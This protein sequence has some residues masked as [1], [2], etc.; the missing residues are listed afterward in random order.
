MLGELDSSS[1]IDIPIKLLSLLVDNNVGNINV[2]ISLDGCIQTETS[3]FGFAT[4]GPK[5]QVS[6]TE[7]YQRKSRDPKVVLLFQ[8]SQILTWIYTLVANRLTPLQRVQ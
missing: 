5:V 8:I 1:L 7:L 3:D 2:L 6:V 4:V